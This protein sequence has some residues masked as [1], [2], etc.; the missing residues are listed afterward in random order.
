MQEAEAVN[1]WFG[2]RA[3]ASILAGDFNA[4]PGSEAI[5]ILHSCWQDTTPESPA[6]TA[7]SDHPR[8]RIDYIMYRGPGLN[9]KS[10]RVI[11]ESI[12]SDHRP[13]LAVFDLTKAAEPSKSPGDATAESQPAPGGKR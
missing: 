5:R 6:A 2:E 11:P 4:E 3:G 10:S 1:R 7:P 13:V 12:A 9:V 8:A